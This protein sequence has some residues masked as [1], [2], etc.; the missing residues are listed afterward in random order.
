MTQKTIFRLYPYYM[1]MDGKEVTGFMNAVSM[2]EALRQ[3]KEDY[4]TS[5][6]HCIY[7]PD[8]LEGK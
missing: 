7:N 8:H 2:E 4:P 3:L 1:K 5:S 6:S